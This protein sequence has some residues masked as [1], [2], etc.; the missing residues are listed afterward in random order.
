MKDQLTSSPQS[1]I[2]QIRDSGWIFKFNLN[3]Y[4]LII[5]HKD[6][7]INLLSCSFNIFV[8]LFNLIF[9]NIYFK[10]TKYHTN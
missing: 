3:L 8:R 9:V 7:L 4:I 5:N 1:I 2:T 10:K 6:N